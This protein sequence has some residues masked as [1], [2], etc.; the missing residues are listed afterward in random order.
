VTIQKSSFPLASKTKFI[1][2]DLERTSPPVR[3]ADSALFNVTKEIRDLIELDDRE[4]DRS[5]Q[6]NDKGKKIYRKW[7]FVEL[8]HLFYA[9]MLKNKL[10]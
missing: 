7:S 1:Y 8:L 3:P 5:A 4:L 9:N 2:F 10:D 6:R